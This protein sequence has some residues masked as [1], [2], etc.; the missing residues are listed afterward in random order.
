MT[1]PSYPRILEIVAPIG[2]LCDY[3]ERKWLLVAMIFK[4]DQ[5]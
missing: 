1:M 5:P 4:G 3:I 2:L